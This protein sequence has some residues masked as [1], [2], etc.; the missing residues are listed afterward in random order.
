MLT[1]KYGLKGTIVTYFAAGLF[2]IV[3]FANLVAIMVHSHGPFRITTHG[4]LVRLDET[5]LTIL[6]KDSE[7]VPLGLENDTDCLLTANQNQPRV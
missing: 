3:I 7:G 1:L 2:H 5:N 6:I 4:N